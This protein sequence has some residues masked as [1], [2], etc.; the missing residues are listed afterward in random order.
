MLVLYAYTENLCISQSITGHLL[1]PQVDIW[2]WVQGVKTACSCSGCCYFW[3]VRICMSVIKCARLFLCVSGSLG[4]EEWGTP[5]LRALKISALHFLSGFNVLPLL[6]PQLWSGAGCVIIPSWWAHGVDG[7][8]LHT[9][10][11]RYNPPG[12]HMSLL[13]CL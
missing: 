8:L 1:E 9:G 4:T 6:G 5:L 11:E 12:I 13:V 7:L 3:T 10:V 2:P